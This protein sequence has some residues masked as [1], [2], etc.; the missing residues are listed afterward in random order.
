MTAPD[1][2]PRRADVVVCDDHTVFTEALAAVL[3]AH[4]FRVRDTAATLAG[5]L[6]AVRAAT[7]AILLLDRHLPDGDGVAALPTLAAASPRTRIVLLSADGD[8]AAVRRAVDG[9]AAGYL[10]KTAGVRDLAHA[11]R[12]VLDGETVVDVPAGRSPRHSPDAAA[13]HRLAAH[14]TPREREC[15]ALLVEGASTAA[16]ERR[17]GVSGTTVRTHVQALLTKLGVHSRLEAASLAVRHRLLLPQPDRA[18][19]T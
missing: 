14:L 11:L 15:L 9:G 19:G 17:L 8:P 6:A 5:A 4:G 18:A 12:R 13:A 1:G 16:M 10:H 2:E 7:P 3:E